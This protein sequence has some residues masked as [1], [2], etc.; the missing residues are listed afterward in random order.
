MKYGFETFSEQP[1]AEARRAGIYVVTEPQKNTKLRQ[2]RHIPLYHRARKMPLLTELGESFSGDFYRYAAPAALNAG[3]TAL[4]I[5]EFFLKHRGRCF[6]GWSTDKVFYYIL[7]NHLHGNVFVARNRSGLI[8]LA[9]IAWLDNA[10]RIRDL[11]A[12]ALPL[13]D[14]NGFPESGDSIVVADVAGDRRL[15]PEILKQVM[16]LRVV[17]ATLATAPQD[18]TAPPAIFQKR[19]FTYRRRKLREL[20]WLAVVR[21]SGLKNLLIGST[22]EEAQGKTLTEKH[23]SEYDQSNQPN[24]RCF[25]PLRQPKQRTQCQNPQNTKQGQPKRDA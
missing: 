11:D 13:F 23:A 2:E 22:C 4:Q 10:A 5:A 6:E 18:N 14:W 3:A 15:M 12:R 19:L 21:F 24:S 16:A 9:A 8:A 17:S 1:P 25:F 7:V 20:S